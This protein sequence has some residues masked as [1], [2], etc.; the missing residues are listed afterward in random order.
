[1]TEVSFVL[2]QR[3]HRQTEEM[4]DEIVRPLCF[5]RV[6]SGWRWCGELFGVACT[7][8]LCVLSPLLSAQ[9]VR[10]RAGRAERSASGVAW[11]TVGTLCE[12]SGGL[13]DRVSRCLRGCTSVHHLC[14][15]GFAG[16]RPPR[17]EQ[18][19][20]FLFGRFN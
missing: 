1:M 17:P 9:L 12:K 13:G 15:Q 4:Q 10:L 11:V 18:N 5:R 7:A 16:H 8:R 6:T 14:V 20:C 2:H 3:P 19:C